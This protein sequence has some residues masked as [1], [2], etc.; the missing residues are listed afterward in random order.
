MRKRKGAPLPDLRSAAMELPEVT[1]DSYN[2]E[3]CDADGFI[4]DHASNR[5]FMEIVEELRQAMR[6]IGNDPLGDEPTRHMGKKTID[7]FLRG[8][9]L[10]AA[11]L[12]QCAIEE[13]AQVLAAVIRR[14]LKEEGWRGT[15]RII[16]GGGLRGSRV[17]E[18]AIGRTTVVL[19][20]EGIPIEI[21]PIRNDPDEAGLIGAAHLVPPAILFDHDA[22]LAV[23]IGGSSI[24]AGVLKLS[25]KEP[26]NLAK[27]KVWRMGQWEHADAKPKPGRDEAVVRLA[28]MLRGLL[29]EAETAKLD[30]APL[31][32]IACPGRIDA[33]GRI[34]S[35]AQNL[36]GNWE[37]ED[38]N[39]PAALRAQVPDIGG[40]ETR[41]VLHNDA[42][43]QGL[44]E[45][46]FMKDVTRW[47][48]LTIGT[49]LGNAR[50]TN[51]YS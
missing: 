25:K 7:G 4:G 20:L 32:G 48:V 40:R 33:D 39:L 9:S 8:G 38:F 17:G 44:S 26:R 23:D 13:F 24:R 6:R 16:A 41:V 19:K 10:E 34:T 43:V 2:L 50:F 3:L 42:V 31:I 28:E 11:G 35:G 1:V 5:A 15:E 49:G 14:F 29:E 21:V 47:G 30:V 27:A 12:I 45:A 37:S 36:P 46:P 51:R 18:L 22:L